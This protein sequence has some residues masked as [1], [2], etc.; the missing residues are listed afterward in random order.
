MLQNQQTNFTSQSHQVHFRITT[1]T[2]TTLL[3]HLKYT[4]TSVYQGEK[5]SH[6]S[7]DLF[8]LGTQVITK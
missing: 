2:Y 5:D 8:N 4:L 1:C 7:S 3:N 6:W